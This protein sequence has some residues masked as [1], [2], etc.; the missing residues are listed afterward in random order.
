MSDSEGKFWKKNLRQKNSQIFDFVIHI[1]IF[2]FYI[3]TIDDHI[4]FASMMLIYFSTP[5]SLYMDFP[6]LAVAKSPHTVLT[7]D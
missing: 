5:T 4:K 2:I 1:I 3:S 7:L 6:S